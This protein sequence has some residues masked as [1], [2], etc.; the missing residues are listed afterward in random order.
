MQLGKIGKGVRLN[1][2]VAYWHVGRYKGGVGTANIRKREPEMKRPI[3]AL[4]SFLLATS[5]WAHPGHG[6][7]SFETHSIGHYLTSG[8]H[9]GFVMVLG[10]AVAAIGS[11][12]WK[13][14]RA[15]QQP[16]AAAKEPGQ[17][18]SPKPS[19]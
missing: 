15:K 5:A 3:L 8:N 19:N 13:A 11:I 16:A 7:V 2:A 18:N 12:I 17:S 4:M 1:A 9:I 14:T 6:N 10:T